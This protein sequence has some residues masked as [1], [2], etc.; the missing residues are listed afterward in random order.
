MSIDGINTLVVYVISQ[1][2]HD[3]IGRLS[4]KPLMSFSM[5]TVISDWCFSIRLSLMSLCA[6]QT[7]LVDT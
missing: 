3:V 7:E 1:Q 5:K 2:S 6:M 4:V